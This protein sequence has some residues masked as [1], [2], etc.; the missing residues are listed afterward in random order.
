[1]ILFIMLLYTLF[2]DTGVRLMRRVEEVIPLLRLHRN[3]INRDNRRKW[4]ISAWFQQKAGKW[5]KLFSRITSIQPQKSQPTILLLI[6]TRNQSTSSPA[7]NTSSKRSKRLDLHPGLLH[8]QTSNNSL[9]YYGSFLFTNKTLTKHWD[10]F[11]VIGA[12]IDA[13]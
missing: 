1:M 8:R 4:K 5:F 3:N 9:Y 7:I 2:S 13:C 11:T 10:R 12:E 6:V